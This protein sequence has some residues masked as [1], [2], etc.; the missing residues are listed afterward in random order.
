MVVFDL[1]P[2]EEANILKSCEVAF[3]GKGGFGQ[4]EAQVPGQSLRLQGNP[5]A[6]ASKHERDL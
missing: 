1:D 5:F 6:R 3:F 4:V 2:G